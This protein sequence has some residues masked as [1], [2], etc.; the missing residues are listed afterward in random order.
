MC[1]TYWMAMAWQ[2][3]ILLYFLGGS[4][5]G[6]PVLSMATLNC[7]VDE[8]GHVRKGWREAGI[9]EALLVSLSL[10]SERL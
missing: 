10:S 8:E 1:I 7:R 5:R 6:I 3:Q 9:W 4:K 2:R